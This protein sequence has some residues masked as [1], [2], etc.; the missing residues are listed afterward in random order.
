MTQSDILFS[1]IEAVYEKHPAQNPAHSRDKLFVS[2]PWLTELGECSIKQP[3]GISHS[4]SFLGTRRKL[5]MPSN[6][7]RGRDSCIPMLQ[8]GVTLGD[9]GEAITDPCMEKL[10]GWSYIRWTEWR[11]IWNLLAHSCAALVPGS[12][13]GL[14]GYKK[15][16]RIIFQLRSGD[17]HI[18]SCMKPRLT[19]PHSRKQ[20]L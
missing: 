7:V 6:N 11:I 14:R 9:K 18:W 4:L 5:W 8:F 3:L 13:Q 12:C 17:S 1:L 10:K 2:C 19:P 16:G 15:G 20:T